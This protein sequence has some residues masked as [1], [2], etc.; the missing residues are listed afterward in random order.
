MQSAR[1]VIYLHIRCSFFVA[2][3]SGLFGH[4]QMLT[5]SA[6]SIPADTNCDRHRAGPFSRSTSL[7]CGF[8]PCRWAWR[9][10]LDP[11]TWDKSAPGAISTEKSVQPDVGGTC[12]GSGGFIVAD[13]GSRSRWRW[14]STACGTNHTDNADRSWIGT[15]GPS[16]SLGSIAQSILLG[17]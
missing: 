16:E 2:V 1:P 15:L 9:T 17:F 4:M 3:G 5:V 10:A 6:K 11:S 7:L 14:Q 12:C 8:F 13:Y